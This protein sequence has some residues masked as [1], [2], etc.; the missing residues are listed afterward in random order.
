MIPKQ[1][2]LPS[3][4]HLDLLLDF[5]EV[6]LHEHYPHLDYTVDILSAQMTECTRCHSAGGE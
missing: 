4:R 6:W 5:L 2:Q 1:V 3:I